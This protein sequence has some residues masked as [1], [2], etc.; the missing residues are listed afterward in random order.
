[1]KKGGFTLIELMVVIFIVGILAAVAVPLM[2]GR[3]DAA[4]WSEGRAIMGTIA[5][6]LRAHVAEEGSNFT[7]VPT[8]AQLGFA[9]NDLD[10]TYFT[11]GESDVGNFSWVINDDDPLDFLITA[12]APAEISTPYQ[13]TLDQDGNWTETAEK[14][15]EPEEPEKPWW[16]PWWW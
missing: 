4:K 8:L 11:G 13:I 16:W 15:E 9:A 10:G 2:R 12:T 14:P 5:T 3:I 6:G 7:A 1:M